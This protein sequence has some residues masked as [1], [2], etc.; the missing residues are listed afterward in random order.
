MKNLLLIICFIVFSSSFAKADVYGGWNDNTLN[1]FSPLVREDPD[2]INIENNY[3]S[4]IFLL[5][6]KNK[7]IETDLTVMEL[8]LTQLEVPTFYY[9]LNS[10]NNLDQYMNLLVKVCPGAVV[11]STFYDWRDPSK[12]RSVA[13]LH[14]GYDI[15]LAAGS[16]V[17]AGWNGVVTAIVP[18]YGSEYGVTVTNKDGISVTYG[19]ISPYARYGQDI[20]IGTLIGFV[21]VDHVDIKMRDS[22]GMFIDFGSSSQA[23]ELVIKKKDNSSFINLIKADKYLLFARSSINNQYA[24]MEYLNK[25]ILYYNLKNRKILKRNFELT[26]NYSKSIKL[27][28]EGCIAKKNLEKSRMEFLMATFGRFKACKER[29]SFRLRIMPEGL[30]IIEDEN[31]IVRENLKKSLSY[32]GALKQERLLKLSKLERSNDYVKVFLLDC[33]SE[34]M[35]KEKSKNASKFPPLSLG[36]KQSKTALLEKELKEAEKFLFNA[37]SQYENAQQLYSLG[38]ISKKDMNELG[39]NYQKALSLYR[40]LQEKLLKL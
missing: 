31:R 2:V 38:Y 37:R 36:M 29:I 12:Y 25:S 20:S 16:P 3:K 14:N 7:D 22:Q 39:D 28:S 35:L 19:H 40:E 33:K 8:K 11:S 26:E 17:I 34:G 24:Y 9:Q 30:S 18:W 23:S 4:N 15:A 32:T 13:G 10:F 1:S 6:Q 27:F 5:L 21:V